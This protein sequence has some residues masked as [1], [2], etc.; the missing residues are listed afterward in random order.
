[1][2]TSEDNFVE[3]N[4]SFHFYVG[5]EVELRLLGFCGKCI[6]FL[7]LYLIFLRLALLLNLDLTSSARL[8]G[9][10]DHARA[11]PFSTSLMLGLYV[12][13]ATSGLLHACKES[14][15]SSKTLTRYKSIIDS[16]QTP[17]CS[18]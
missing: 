9:Q 12:N 18:F 2:L 16:P 17:V 14:I 10:Q 3:S 7:A 1:M 4:P 13:A 5:S 15:L 11:L 6:Y 8:S